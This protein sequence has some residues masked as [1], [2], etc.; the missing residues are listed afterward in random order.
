M[1]D[2]V[3]VLRSLTRIGTVAPS[4]DNLASGERHHRIG[5]CDAAH[6]H[7]QPAGAVR[8]H[9]PARIVT[10][11]RRLDDFLS[12]PTHMASGQTSLSV[13]HVDCTT[14][15][16]CDSRMSVPVALHGCAWG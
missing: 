16:K 6:E 14:R 13:L 10:R 4:R 8:I 5:A 3:T 7:V 12:A 9:T 11:P 15:G 2:V 1:H